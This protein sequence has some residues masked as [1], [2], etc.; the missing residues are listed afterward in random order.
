M[1]KL[2]LIFKHYNRKSYSVLPACL[3]EEWDIEK[4]ITTYYDAAAYGG[5]N[6]R[7]LGTLLET[8]ENC[9]SLDQLSQQ[10]HD[11]GENQFCALSRSV[12]ESR[13]SDTCKTDRGGPLQ[14]I[15]STSLDYVTCNNPVVI[16]LNSLGSACSTIDKVNV[17]TKIGNYISWIEKVI[18]GEQP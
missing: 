10:I 8:E 16:G 3:N 15:E 5:S 11:L 13:S 4:S 12:Q 6:E 17:Y 18:F 2:Y 9:D 14:Y 7:V 1:I